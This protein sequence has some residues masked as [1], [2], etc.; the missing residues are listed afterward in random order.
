MAQSYGDVFAEVIW[1]VEVV[2]IL[3][4]DI[5]EF[6]YVR[7]K[8]IRR[9][10]LSRLRHVYLTVWEFQSIGVSVL[11]DTPSAVKDHIGDVFRRVR[12]GICNA[13]P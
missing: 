12:W 5:R 11:E 7:V 8:I 9:V 13:R 3:V 2:D 1:D 4:G 6:M 10:I